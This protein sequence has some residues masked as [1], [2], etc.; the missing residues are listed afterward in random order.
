[1]N[2][3]LSFGKH[4]GKTFEWLFF[5]EPSYAEFIYNN[6]IHR[7]SHNFSEEECEHFLELFNRASC[8]TGTC[9]WCRER[10]VTRMGLSYQHGSDALGHIGFFCDECDYTGGSATGYYTPSFFVE[11]YTLPRG[12]QRRLATFIKTRYIGSE[13]LT[14]AKMEEFFHNDANFVHATPGFFAKQ[15]AAV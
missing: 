11:E 4:A 2:N 9:K 13:R 5:K 12:E 15:L 7:Q 6:G 10:P 3:T 1:M 14:Q 8:L